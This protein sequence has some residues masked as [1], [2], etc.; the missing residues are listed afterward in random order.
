MESKLPGA[1]CAGCT[2]VTSLRAVPGYGPTDAS[3][4]IVG[5]APGANEESQG[6]PFVGESGRLLDAALQQSGNPT[7]F[8]TNVVAC[9]PPGNRE[10]TELEIQCCRPRLLEE[11]RA[12]TSNR[13]LALGNTAHGAFNAPSGEKGAVFVRGSRVVM[14]AWHPAYILRA[15]DDATEFL[16]QVD[17]AVR[18]PMIADAIKFPEVVW[19]EDLNHL[20]LLLNECPDNAWVAFDIET[21]QVRWYP[22]TDKGPDQILMAQFTWTPD[23]AVI[24]SDELLYDT[25][26]IALQGILQP[27][28]DRVQV[29]GHNIKFDAVFMQAHLGIKIKQGFDTMLAH[30][31]L[32]E[33]LPHGLKPIARL[34]FGIPDYEEETIG[35]YLN[36]RNDRYSKVPAPI[37]AKYGGMDV[38]I[39]LLLR[40][41]YEE[42]LRAEGLY[43]WPFKNILMR[44]ANS[45]AQVEL[46]GFKIDVPQLDV[47][48]AALDVEIQN[49]T[50]QI[51]EI[52]NDPG[53]NPN[54]TAQMAT[55]FYDKLHLP[56]PRGRKI[57]PRSVGKEARAKLMGKHPV[58]AIFGDYKRITKM[59]SS[60]VTNLLSYV[61]TE[62]RVHANFKIPGTEVGRISV[63]D[64]ALQTIPRADDYYGALIR[65]SFVPKEGHVLLIAD[66]SQAELRVFADQ[67]KE[68]FLIRVYN[69]DR[70]LHSEVAI[71]MFGVGY[72]KAQRVQ[73]KMFNFS[74]LYGGT[75]HSF[76]QDA[77]LNIQIARDFVANYNKMMP[78]GLAYKQSQLKTLMADGFVS[79][80]FGRRRHFPFVVSEN[81]DEARKACVHMPI[82]A[83]ASD[84]TLM[85]ACQ[86]GDE[87][88]LVVL[89]VHDSVVAECPIEDVERIGARMVEVMQHMGEE[90]FPAVK[91][92]VD[93]EV[94]NRWA[95]PLPHP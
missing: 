55:L 17:S 14:P 76:A 20:A 46:R 28:F 36:S 48:A 85:S 29:V 86:L 59:R 60:Y 92:K 57:K 41:R 62:G 94:R 50:S 71:A 77:G 49:L 56:I 70:D 72:T 4:I 26:R 21:D 35:P 95:D 78:V 80:R 39:T 51:R 32:N 73:C 37:L 66:Y 75:E 34:E 52:A 10:P 38:V 44:A 9:R 12:C 90:Y 88:I 33:N 65:S 11:I 64:P 83:S 63:A 93:L 16:A 84:L 68:P 1:L 8:K 23:R 53:L 5:E 79:S 30:Y 74:Y 2:L 81:Q 89:T 47:I 7:I 42:R 69:E 61:D 45:L 43:D 24:V 13:I 18:G 82:A 3:V 6:L 31:A 40:E 19:A 91:W 87:G 15:P 54:A 27:F 67:S 58:V 25:D 22:T